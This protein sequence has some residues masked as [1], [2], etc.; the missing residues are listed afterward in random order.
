MSLDPSQDLQNKAVD[1]EDAGA[2]ADKSTDPA[3]SAEA[4]EVVKDAE[5]LA[6]EAV[7]D[8]EQVVKDA[9]GD[10]KDV[11][12]EGE[13][14]VSDVSHGDV[15][16][17]V[18]EGEGLI[19][20]V[21]DGVKGLADEALADVGHL[22]EDAKGLVDDAVEAAKDLLHI[23]GQSTDEDDAAEAAKKAQYDAVHD[24]AARGGDTAAN[25]P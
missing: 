5:A 7:A 2:P 19:E 11:L 14:V 8:A 10:A 6:K 9:E 18:K 13:A 21:V 20:K 22:A 25:R 4:D 24:L 15:P 3:A 16:G 12:A 23:G 1:A 17:A